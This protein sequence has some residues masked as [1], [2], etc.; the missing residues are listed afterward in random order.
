M[1]KQTKVKIVSWVIILL[2]LGA[3][4]VTVIAMYYDGWS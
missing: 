4:F 3:V 1:N 2:M